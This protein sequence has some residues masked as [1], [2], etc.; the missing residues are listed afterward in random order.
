M[1]TYATEKERSLTPA[2]ICDHTSDEVGSVTSTSLGLDDDLKVFAKL[3]EECKFQHAYSYQSGVEAGALVKQDVFLKDSSSN[4]PS[5]YV[6]S[7]HMFSNSLLSHTPVFGFMYPV[8]GNMDWASNHDN[9]S[10]VC[11]TSKSTLVDCTIVIHLQIKASLHRYR[12]WKRV[13]LLDRSVGWIAF[14]GGIVPQDLSTSST[15]GIHEAGFCS[16]FNS[17][18]GAKR[19]IT[20]G[21]GN[22]NRE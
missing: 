15:R 5:S 11:G 7:M 9:G 21:G 8:R 4:L 1:S 16:S 18:D 22:R 13:L 17:L 6:G 2:I 20:A 14:D 10:I 3:Q 19:S 12:Y